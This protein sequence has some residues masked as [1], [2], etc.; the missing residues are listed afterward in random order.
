MEWDNGHGLCGLVYKS[1]NGSFSKSLS[2]S[3]LNNSTD[4]KISQ[5]AKPPEN[6]AALDDTFTADELQSAGEMQIHVDKLKYYM[7]GLLSKSSVKLH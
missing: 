5:I 6:Y 7:Q 3:S 2:S 1:K 4:G